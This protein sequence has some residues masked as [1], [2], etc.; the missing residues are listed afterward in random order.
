M[1]GQYV[2][3]VKLIAL[4]LLVYLCLF[5]TPRWFP[6]KRDC[7]IDTDAASVGVNTDPAILQKGQEFVLRP[8]PAPVGQP[9]T[10]VEC[11]GRNTLVVG[12]RG[13]FFRCAEYTVEGRPTTQVTEVDC[14][15]VPCGS[16][17]ERVGPVS[18]RVRE[19]I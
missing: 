15:G 6:M 5:R 16:T 10:A 9:K 2:D 8:F 4:I 11:V 1:I 17:T 7:D 13:R 14:R 3:G 18:D 12:R 19:L